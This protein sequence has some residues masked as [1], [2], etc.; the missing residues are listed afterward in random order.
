MIMF[1]AVR[2]LLLCQTRLLPPLKAL[3]DFDEVSA[4]SITYFSSQRTTCKRTRSIYK[5]STLARG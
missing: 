3:L 4:S 2:P 1:G 5:R